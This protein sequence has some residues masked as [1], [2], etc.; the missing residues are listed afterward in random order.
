M[1]LFV[2]VHFHPPAVHRQLATHARVNSCFTEQERNVN[3]LAD[4]LNSSWELYLKKRLVDY[5]AQYL[6]QSIFNSTTA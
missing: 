3:V 6:Y 5:E 2:S 4:M 1:F